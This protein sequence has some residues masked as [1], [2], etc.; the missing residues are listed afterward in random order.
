M[1]G[2]GGDAVCFGVLLQA[3][4]LLMQIHWRG[5]DPCALQVHADPLTPLP[6]GTDR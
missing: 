3:Q 5:V 2:V 4:L 6:P 1:L